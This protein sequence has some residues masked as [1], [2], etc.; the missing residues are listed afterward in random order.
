MYARIYP[1]RIS[2]PG[3]DDAGELGINKGG[4]GPGNDPDLL[5]PAGSVEFGR[6]EITV[7]NIAVHLVLRWIPGGAHL[8]GA[9]DG[10]ALQE[11]FRI[12]EGIE[13]SRFP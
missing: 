1:G 2:S 6:H 7:S 13:D 4:S 8:P 10:D 12:P 5:F 11:P 9:V 3:I